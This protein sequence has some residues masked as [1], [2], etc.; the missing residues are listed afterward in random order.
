MRARILVVGEDPADRALY[1]D[2]LQADGYEFLE[3]ETEEEALLLLSEG[4][5]LILLDLPSANGHAVDMAGRL[6]RTGRIP[7]VV[8]TRF[9]GVPDN[10][11]AEGVRRFI[12][13]PCRPATL[14]DGISQVLRYP[15]S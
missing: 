13:K 9:G 5:N 15:R 1:R 6:H 10:P 11:L 7:V 14:L 3:A 4:P 2:L 8:V 12:Y